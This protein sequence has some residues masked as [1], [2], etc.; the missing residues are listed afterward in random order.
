ML[1]DTLLTLVL[2]LALCLALICAAV[3]CVVALLRARRT[4]TADVVRALPELAAVFL[5]FR[6]QPRR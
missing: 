2:P 5:R 4:D 1:P 3:V 6:R